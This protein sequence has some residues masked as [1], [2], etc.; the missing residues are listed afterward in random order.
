MEQSDET[1]RKELLRLLGE[2]NLRETEARELLR[3]LT[4]A[5]KVDDEWG[6]LN[7]DPSPE[8]EGISPRVR[9]RVLS[10]VSEQIQPSSP[11]KRVK[12][13][14]GK[15]AVAAMVLL[16]VSL[17]FW[18]RA[19]RSARLITVRTGP[20]E[21]RSLV[22]PDESV[23]TL[24]GNS[25]LIY[26]GEW[27]EDSPRSVQLIGEADFEVS[28]HPGSGTKFRVVTADLSVEV[29]GT[30]FEVST[31]REETEVRL[32]E[33]RVSIDLREPANRQLELHPGEEMKFS[34]RHGQLVPPH[35]ARR[36]PIPPSWKQGYLSFRQ[37]TLADICLRLSATHD[38]A[39]APLDPGV[40]DRAFTLTLPLGDLN[41]MMKLLA[42]STGTELHRDGD[43][44]SLQLPSSH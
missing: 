1:R 9:Q 29:L 28:R 35:P 19:E 30:V 4:T 34:A 39:V 14:W 42:R 6:G 26:A 16:V 21:V 38:L 25:T 22:L 17:W 27:A 5:D 8:Q 10:R 15:L 37:A 32:R 31:Y 36:P 23:V 44:Y 3:L 18:E 41:R 11:P 40:A 2:G 24:N 33:G 13:N 7:A 12:Q 20:G 43:T